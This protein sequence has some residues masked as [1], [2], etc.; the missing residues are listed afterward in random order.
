[1]KKLL[2]KSL[3]L[4]FL[5]ILLAGYFTIADPMK[6]FF[7]YE[8]PLEKGVLMNDRHFQYNWLKKQPYAYDSFIFGSSRSKA[9]KTKIWQ[10]YIGN[11]LP[12]HMGVN[13]ET[14]Y[15]IE[16]KLSYLDNQGYDIKNVL[17][18]LD[19]RIIQ[20]HYNQ[21][22]HI[23]REHYALS[24][25]SKG[26]YY[27]RF[28]IAFLKPSFLK[29]YFSL[30][31]NNEIEEWMLNV[32][33][34]EDFEYLKKT[35]DHYYNKFEEELKT[36]S[37]GYYERRSS[38][39]YKRNIEYIDTLQKIT[40]I[41]ENQIRGIYEILSRHNAYYKIVI[42]PTYCQTPLHN[43]DLELLNTVFGKNS[44]Y[45]YSGSNNM[46]EN[47]GNFYEER[48]FKPYIANKILKDIYND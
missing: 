41:A 9:F 25:E 46:T 1:M 21:N 4:L 24:G 5:I 39:F 38:V 28:F 37:I 19:T 17:I 45:N 13:D 16:R 27:K 26:E 43:K 15:G 8:S 44:V 34:D 3:L 33:W 22:A 10:E 11:S 35:A 31:F 32:I 23:F 47:I 18:V 20:L 7:E 48:H 2:L 40:N 12:F 6:I 30:K 36:D 29:A 14:L 42:S